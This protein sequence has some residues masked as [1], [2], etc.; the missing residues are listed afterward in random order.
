MN[1]N[2]AIWSHWP[3]YS[4]KKSDDNL[5]IL[6]TDTVTV[7]F[8]GCKRRISCSIGVGFIF[9]SNNSNAPIASELTNSIHD[10]ERLKD[11]E[12]EPEKKHVL[13]CSIEKMTLV[14]SA[15]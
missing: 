10:V 1:N 15:F 7:H 11:E 13:S 3:R 5:Q 4:V 8:G 6:P 12:L 14:N 9:G 2:L